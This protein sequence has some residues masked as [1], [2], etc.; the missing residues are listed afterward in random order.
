MTRA[1]VPACCKPYR[2]S[3]PST[4][5]ASEGP[6]DLSG[7]QAPSLWQRRWFPWAVIGGLVVLALPLGALVAFLVTQEQAADPPDC[8]GLGF[9]CVPGPW[10]TAALMGIAVYAPA[11]LT[12]GAVLGLAELFGRHFQAV[13]SAIA[14]VGAAV[15]VLISLVLVA[16]VAR[17]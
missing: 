4:V 2:P 6:A 11:L 14:V 13:R 15:L 16:T 9:G 8:D 3:R 5:V 1:P 17:S 12:L 10:D 7:R